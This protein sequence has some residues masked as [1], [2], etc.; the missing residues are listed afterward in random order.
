MKANSLA[1]RWTAAAA[2]LAKA[3]PIVLGG[4]FVVERRGRAL[5]AWMAAGVA[6]VAAGVTWGMRAAARP[7]RV[8]PPA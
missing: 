3:W 7:P 4:A 6:L 5:G 8:V 1:F 2:V